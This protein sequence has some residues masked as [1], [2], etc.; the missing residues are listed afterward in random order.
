M[1]EEKNNFNKYRN[2]NEMRYQV[3][4]QPV[5]GFLFSQGMELKLKSKW[6]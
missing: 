4:G 1:F 3:S 5:Q 2:Y 6:L